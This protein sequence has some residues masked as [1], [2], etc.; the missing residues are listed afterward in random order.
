MSRFYDPIAPYWG[1]IKVAAFVLPMAGLLAWGMRVDHLRA[2]YKSALEELTQEAA[3]VVLAIR[4]A[5]ENEEVTWQTASGQVIAMGES[6]RSLKAAVARQNQTID[7]MAKEAVRLKA[8][9]ADLKKIADRAE[10]QRQSALRRLSDMSITPGTRE[11]CMVLLKEAEEA[12][13]LVREAGL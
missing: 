5:S 11:D 12:L 8:K 9:A 3:T 13:N 4:Q 1:A 6:N 2:G 7:D 10:A